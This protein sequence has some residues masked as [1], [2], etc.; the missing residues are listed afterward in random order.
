MGNIDQLA[1][2]VAA[3]GALSKAEKARRHEAAKQDRRKERRKQKQE[4]MARARAE[5]WEDRDGKARP[6]EHRRRH[7]AFRLRDT[8]DAGVTVAVDEQA[9]ILD[10]ME[11][12]GTITKRQCQAGHMFN[13]VAR[14]VI[15]SPSQRSCLDFSPVGHDGDDESPDAIRAASEWRS[16]RACLTSGQR[17]QC[18][19]VCWQ[20]LGPDSYHCMILGLNAVADFFKL[21]KERA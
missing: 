8:E 19:R 10:K 16:L 4:D 15:G 6:T 11:A 21:E 13:E 20:D 14:A 9:T 3:S 2:S 1:K 17:N 12:L 7:G 18:L 5:I